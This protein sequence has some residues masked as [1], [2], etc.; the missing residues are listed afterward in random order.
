VRRSAVKRVVGWIVFALLGVL[1]WAHSA[2]LAL[3]LTSIWWATQK[4]FCP[5][6]G[7]QDVAFTFFLPFVVGALTATFVLVRKLNGWLPCVPWFKAW[8]IGTTV[9]GVVILVAPLIRGLIPDCDWELRHRVTAFDGAL[10]ENN[11]RPAG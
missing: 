1:T 10:W 8:V 7:L 9:I 2:Y 5:Y 3:R 6:S 4:S 11:A